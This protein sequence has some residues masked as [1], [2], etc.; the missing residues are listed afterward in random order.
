MQQL[1]RIV[2]ERI[3]GKYFLDIS[4]NSGW[5]VLKLTKSMML[6]KLLFHLLRGFTTAVINIFKGLSGENSGRFIK[7]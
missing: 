2:L 4:Y 7:K 6:V 1:E 3:R 5:E